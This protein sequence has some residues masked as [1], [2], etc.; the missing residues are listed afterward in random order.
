MADISLATLLASARCL[1]SSS[2]SLDFTVVVDRD[3]PESSITLSREK[4]LNTK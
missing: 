3:A 1:P 4:T 2:E